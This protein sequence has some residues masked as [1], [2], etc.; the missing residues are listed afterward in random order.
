M[1]CVQEKR[2]KEKKRKEMENSQKLSL[3]AYGYNTYAVSEIRHQVLEDAINEHGVEAVYKRLSDVLDY[4][5]RNVVSYVA[6]LNDMF[7]LED[8]IWQR[9]LFRLF[10]I[11]CSQ[12]N[13]YTHICILSY[14]VATPRTS[15]MIS[16]S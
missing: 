3:R 13:F 10:Y 1:M 14:L 12:F 4:Q 16:V 2:R 8:R 6:I 5:E 11:V 15:I 9:K 7:Y